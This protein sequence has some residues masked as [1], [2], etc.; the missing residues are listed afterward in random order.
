MRILLGSHYF[1]PSTGGIET[2][3]NLLAQQFVELGHEVRVVTTTPG[4]GDFPF[5]V[6]RRPSS[7]AL[8]R[9]IRWCEVFLQNNISL[10]TLWPLAF[11]HRPLF[12]IHQTWISGPDGGI[13]WPE[14]LKRFVLRYAVSFAISR[15]VADALPVESTLI[16]NPYDDKVF[17]VTPPVARDKQLIFVGRLV[18]DKGADLLL[19][20]LTNV[21]GK[22]GLTIAGDGPERARLEKQ[23]S[24]LGLTGQ[25]DFVGAKGSIELAAMLRRHR[26]LVVP[27]RWKEPFGIVALEGIA[28]GC[29]VIGSAAG[30]LSE[31]IGRCGITVPNGDAAALAE[32]ISRLLANPAEFIALQQNTVAHLER[33][34]PQRIAKLLLERMTGASL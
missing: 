11:V 28:C 20:A 10:R 27:S 7:G 33:F 25:V 22:P 1:F 18:S 19:E 16:G 12:V 24:D 8:L 6:V 30:G 26:I 3:T 15:S 21:D 32:A 14:R 34:A 23:A 2:V 31:A 17:T 13:G 5:A 4:H 29:I 9:E